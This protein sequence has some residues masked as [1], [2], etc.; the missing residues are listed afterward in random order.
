MASLIIRCGTADCDLGHRVSDLGEG[1]LNLCRSEFR[2]HCIQ[3]H[4]LEE[5]DAKHPSYPGV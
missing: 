3:R 2:K 4:K 1:Q 5:W